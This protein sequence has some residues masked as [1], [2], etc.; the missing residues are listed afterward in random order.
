MRQRR[1][2][3]SILDGFVFK[4]N[5]LSVIL[6]LR[7]CAKGNLWLGPCPNVFSKKVVSRVVSKLTH[8]ATQSMQYARNWR[9]SQRDWRKSRN[10]RRDW[11]I[12]VTH[13][14]KQKQIKSIFSYNFRTDILGQKPQH[15]RLRTRVDYFLLN[16]L[17]SSTHTPWPRKWPLTR[18]YPSYP[19]P[20]TSNRK[21]WW[22]SLIKL[23]FIY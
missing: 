15:F 19:W 11:R 6:R 16:M 2:K 14:L 10:S 4:T 18:N 3:W 5:L 21:Y 23:L 9:N 1:N 8:F 20:L 12:L 17:I 22:L 13:P 7:A